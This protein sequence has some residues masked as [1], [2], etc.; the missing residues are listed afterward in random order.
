MR[1]SGLATL[2]L[3]SAI[4]LAQSPAADSVKQQDRIAS[5]E[6][7]ADSV[8]PA[9]LLPLR[10]LS[11]PYR[12]VT[13]GMESGLIAFERHKVRERAQI[14]TDDL[15]RRGVDLRF[16]GT[17]EG[18]GIGGGILYRIPTGESASIGLLGLITAKRYQEAD[19]NWTLAEGIHRLVAES[20]YQ[21]RPQENFY[22]LGHDSLREKHS[23]F[24]LRQSWGGLRYEVQPTRHVRTGL[25][26]RVAWMSALPGRNPAYASPD[27]YTTGLAGYGTQTRLES[28][29]AYF[30][31]DVIRQEYQ[32]GCAAHFGASHQRGLGGSNVDYYAYETQLEG[33]LPLVSGNS[34]LV[35]QANIELNR[36]SG[37]SGEIPFYLLPH[38]GGSSTLRGF[39]L[40]RFYG[41]NLMLLSL[42]YRYRVH[43]NMQAVPFFDEGQV[44]DRTADVAWLNWHRNYGFGFRFRTAAG[45]FL[46]IDYGRSSEGFQI[47]VTFGD[48]ERPPLRGPIRYGG[49][50]R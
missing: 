32:L 50:K 9:A 21:W 22:G 24:A 13:D 17:G 11:F 15:H 26:Y 39:A 31:L 41:T 10:I 5:S 37:G 20:S 25:L 36:R 18:T 27:V 38:I 6:E 1:G 3:C 48:R 46:R 23:Q 16:G 30:D 43:P 49:Y 8:H 45:P 28:A 14:W 2:V 33:R 44:F 4:G 40:D 34:V 29:G 12:K 47:D 19:L 35:G 42:E 7:I